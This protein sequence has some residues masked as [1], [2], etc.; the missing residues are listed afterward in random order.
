MIM[1]RRSENASNFGAA[2][3]GLMLVQSFSIHTGA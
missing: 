2:L 1:M 3:A